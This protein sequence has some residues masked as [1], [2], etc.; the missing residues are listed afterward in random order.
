MIKISMSP[1]QSCM[2]IHIRDLN[3]KHRPPI[4]S[5]KTDPTTK[6]SLSNEINS[7][8][9]YCLMDFAEQIESEG[10][11]ISV[12]PNIKQVFAN[13]SYRFNECPVPFFPANITQPGHLHPHRVLKPPNFLLLFFKNLICNCLKLLHKGHALAL[14][15]S[16]GP[17]SHLPSQPA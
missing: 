5:L 4:I 12:K 17:K 13:Q 14:P 10:A 15:R 11:L 7:N 6:S 16:I 9:H 3:M 2:L 1:R 8:C